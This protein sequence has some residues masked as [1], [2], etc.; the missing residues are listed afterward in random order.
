VRGRVTRRGGVRDWSLAPAL[1]RT[2]GGARELVRRR[3]E[4]HR[5]RRRDRV[6][7][8]VW[9]IHD[10]FADS[11]HA[12]GGGDLIEGDHQAVRSLAEQLDLP[13]D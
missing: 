11:Q 10:G 2:S 12:E 3:R 13:V 6:G 4:H 9:T 5:R 1:A 7:G 8:R